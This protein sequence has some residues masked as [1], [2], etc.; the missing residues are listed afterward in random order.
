MAKRLSASGAPDNLRQHLSS[1]YAGLVNITLRRV[2][3]PAVVVARWECEPTPGQDPHTAEPVDSLDDLVAAVNEAAEEHVAQYGTGEYRVTTQCAPGSRGP[4]AAP[5]SVDFAVA[6]GAPA[7]HTAAVRDL[8]LDLSKYLFGQ[9]KELLAANV[10][11]LKGMGPIMT[12][13]ADAH[14]Q[15]AADRQAIASDRWEHRAVELEAA[16]SAARRAMVEKVL[17]PILPLLKAEAVKRLGGAAAQAATPPAAAPSDADDLVT[18]VAAFRSTLTAEQIAALPLDLRAKLDSATDRSAVFALMALVIER[19]DALA[20]VL[21]T[22]TSH[23]EALFSK[24]HEAVM[25][26]SASPQPS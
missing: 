24:L 21:A 11:L 4:A 10:E 26:A 6:S 12:S 18:M 2:A 23:Q 22:F 14:R 7:D 3:R 16:E 8:A 1:H 9:V 13:M 25:R 5:K 17:M 20:P 19:V 15:L